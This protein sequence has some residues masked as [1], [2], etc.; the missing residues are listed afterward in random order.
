MSSCYHLSPC[1]W[2]GAADLQHTHR[3]PGA[4]P[5]APNWPFK[6]HLFDA[7]RALGTVLADFSRH[8]NRRIFCQP[9]CTLLHI[10]APIQGLLS[11]FAPYLA[12][13]SA[14]VTW[15]IAGFLSLDVSRPEPCRHITSAKPHSIAYSAK[16]AIK[17][18]AINT[19]Y[20]RISDRNI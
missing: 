9:P 14:S 2:H 1:S 19:I 20:K 8:R 4:A 3:S 18:I 10:D 12:L 13:M 15:V 11:C 6:K 5:L 7:W 17:N 16:K